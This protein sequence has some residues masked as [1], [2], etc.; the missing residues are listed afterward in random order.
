MAGVVSQSPCAGYRP[1]R[2][3]HPMPGMVAC[4]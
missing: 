2:Y 4:R 3:A 1:Q